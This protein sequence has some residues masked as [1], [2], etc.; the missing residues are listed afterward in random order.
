MMCC[1]GVY[2]GLLPRGAVL[3]PTKSLMERLMARV[4]VLDWFLLPIMS[5]AQG[6]Y[7]EGHT[8]VR[9]KKQVNRHTNNQTRPLLSLSLRREGHMSIRR[10]KRNER[11]GERTD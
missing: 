4:R 5:L 7:M 8:D 10:R 11:A 6:P 2:V 9:T 1:V 3:A